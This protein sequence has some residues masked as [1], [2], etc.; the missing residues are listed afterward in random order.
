MCK[1]GRRRR[2][3][4]VPGLQTFRT[5]VFRITGRRIGRRFPINWTCA[6]NKL[7]FRRP[8]KIHYALGYYISVRNLSDSRKTERTI[9]VV[10][11]RW[12]QNRIFLFN[13]RHLP[14]AIPNYSSNFSGI[15]KNN[16]WNFRQNRSSG[17]QVYKRQPYI[18]CLLIVRPLTFFLPVGSK[19]SIAKNLPL[20][21]RIV[22]QKTA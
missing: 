2:A 14:D 9:R 15:F 22:L 6:Q 17:F 12:W 7:P 18:H 3:I 20:T 10:L 11:F 4:R 5:S 21:T 8:V 16:L 13:Q 1:C 19:I